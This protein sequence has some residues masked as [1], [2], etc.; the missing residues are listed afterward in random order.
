MIEIE[1]T[2][3]IKSLI[4]K[5]DYDRVNEFRWQAAFDKRRRNWVAK[6]TIY[7]KQNDKVIYKWIYL[8]RFVLGL[9]ELPKGMCVD[10]INGD[11]LDNR[12]SNLRVCSIYENNNNRKNLYRTNTSGFTGIA[13][14]G[15]KTYSASVQ[16]NGLSVRLGCYRSINKAIF[17][18][19]AVAF[20]C[21]GD[22]A[23]LNKPEFLFWVAL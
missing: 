10:H 23:Y 18:R 16:I 15:Y 4:D 1:L 8:H 13:S 2:Q 12:K 17:W 3:G 20:Y 19:D 5:E 11:R 9:D 21:N 14:T 6:R 22:Y 7:T